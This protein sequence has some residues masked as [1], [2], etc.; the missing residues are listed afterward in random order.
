MINSQPS[1]PIVSLRGVSKDF[2]VGGQTATALRGINLDIQRGEIFSIIGSSGA[3]KS[4]LVRLINLLERPTAGEIVFNGK[5]ITLVKGA[6]L[7]TIRRSIG[8]VFQHFNLLSAKTVAENVAFPLKLSGARDRSAIAERVSK[9]LSRVGLQEHAAKYPK[10]LS[11]GQK[12]RVGIARALALQPDVLLCDEATSALDPQTT[13][14]VL[15]LLAEINRDL[16]I[17]IVLITH[18]MD[19]VRQISHRVAVLDHGQIV[20]HGRVEDVFLHPGHAKTRELVHEAEPE[21]DELP[22]GGILRG[23]IYRLTFVGKRAHTPILGSV[24]REFGIDYV[25]TGGRVGTIRDVPYAQLTISF[26]DGNVRG[27]IARLITSGVSAE[28]LN[29]GASGAPLRATAT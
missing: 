9:L 16:G 18:E 17:T 6:E 19:V 28:H 10:Q 13:R 15:K 5:P 2:L 29:G 7:R 11:G 27:A 26:T 21:N 25:I 1:Q 3:G 4:T 12:Q 22:R 23:Q 8:M 14:S 24:A 20:E